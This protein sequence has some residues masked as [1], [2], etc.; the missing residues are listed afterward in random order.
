M[1][2][3]QF[4]NTARSNLEQFLIEREVLINLDTFKVILFVSR[5]LLTIKFL[6]FPLSTRG[7]VSRIQE[8]QS[9]KKKISLIDYT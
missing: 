3:I 2:S 1:N 4:T 7:P 5:S 6:F 9:K 8:I